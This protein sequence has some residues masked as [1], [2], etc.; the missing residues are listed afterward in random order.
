MN[1]NKWKTFGLYG[2][3]NSK[4]IYYKIQDIRRVENKKFLLSRDHSV[5]V[6]NIKIPSKAHPCLNLMVNLSRRWLKANSDLTR[7][8][9]MH[10]LEVI[11]K[12]YH[13]WTKPC[14]WNWVEETLQK[15]LV[16]MLAYGCMSL[17]PKFQTYCFCSNV[18]LCQIMPSLS[19]YLGI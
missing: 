17:C 10:S 5:H 8:C 14:E 4:Y 19:L 3:A 9:I 12:L 16:V 13:G 6:K 1:K 11:E 15:P 2:C 7:W 18:L